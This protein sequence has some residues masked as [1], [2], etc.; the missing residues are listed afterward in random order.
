M[1]EMLTMAEAATEV[2]LSYYRFAH[3]HA[4]GEGPPS[5]KKV[6]RVFFEMKP[7]RL[8]AAKR[9]RRRG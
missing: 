9:R 6:S 7:L 5:V 8:W 2:G 3:L 4:A 1:P